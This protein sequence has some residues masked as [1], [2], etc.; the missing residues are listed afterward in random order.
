MK[1]RR[2]YPV[3]QGLDPKTMTQ[4]G[5]VTI[6]ASDAQAE[7][8]HLVILVPNY[9]PTETGQ[10]V[11]SYTMAHRS[12]VLKPELLKKIATLEDRANKHYEQQ[13]RDTL[14]GR[15]DNGAGESAQASDTPT[16][17]RK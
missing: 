15:T 14:R 6:Q 9:E 12:D 1:I 2:R 5:Q 11:V 16:E 3:M 13:R 10:K 7:A 17:Q 4:V 8:L